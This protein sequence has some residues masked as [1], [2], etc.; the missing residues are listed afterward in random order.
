VAIELKRIEVPRGAD[1][2]MDWS[3]WGMEASVY[4]EGTLAVHAD[5]AQIKAWMDAHK[6]IMDMA[7][8]GSEDAEIIANKIKE[9]LRELYSQKK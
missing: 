9:R 8:A 2:N 3:K 1:M 4:I 5:R 7:A 6:D